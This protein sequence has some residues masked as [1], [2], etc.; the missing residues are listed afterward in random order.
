MGYLE[1]PFLSKVTNDRTKFLVTAGTTEELDAGAVVHRPFILK[2]VAP[3]TTKHVVTTYQQLFQGIQ[4]GNL[5]LQV[6]RNL[7]IRGG[8][9]KH[10]LVA[11]THSQLSH[12]PPDTTEPDD[13]EFFT[14]HQIPAQELS[15]EVVN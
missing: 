4:T 2:R 14:A 1:T 5:A 6:L 7:Q 3:G 13:A 9:I 8:I 12:S 15:T 11:L 10:Y